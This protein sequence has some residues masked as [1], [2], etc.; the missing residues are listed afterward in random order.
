[1]QRQPPRPRVLFDDDNERIS[2]HD[3]IG[4]SKLKDKADRA[5]TELV[6]DPKTRRLLFNM[7]DQG[8]MSRM[9]GV[10]STGKEANVY[11]A[12]LD[13]EDGGPSVYKAVKVYK[14]SILV[15]KDR[16]RYVAGEHRFM[17]GLKKTSNKAMV[18]GWAE[19][20]YRNLRRLD[21]AKIPCPEPIKIKNNV[22]LM[23]FL[24]NEQGLAY[25]RLKDAPISQEEDA[26]EIW[27][28]LAIQALGLMRRL[29]RICSLVHAD[30][31]EYNI[32]YNDKT[33]Y[34]IDVSQSVEHH[35]P[36]AMEFLRMDVKNMSNFFRSKGVD[37]LR[38]STMIDFITDRKA[39]VSEPSMSTYIKNLYASRPEA[40]SEAE[41]AQAR[42]ADNDQ[43]RAMEFPAAISIAVP[44]E[45][46]ARDLDTML[47]RALDLDEDEDTTDEED[48]AEDATDDE[49]AEESQD[50]ERG[51]AAVKVPRGMRF[52]PKDEKKAHKLDVKEQ[53]REKRKTK[54][55]KNVKKRLVAESSRKKT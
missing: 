51:G 6:L 21:M 16:D 10:I 28:G 2:G 9:E 52:K 25:P 43:F 47:E 33:L 27:A 32:L 20:E 4:H 8:L 22:L 31:S 24:G 40:A 17:R 42:D 1:M 19:K 36:K 12:V 38:D 37:V 26:D 55:P 5:T 13:P 41:A 30:L 44:E 18:A 46:D 53:K 45:M 29:Y 35:H 34:I 50:E 15:F 23:S 49:D 7:I 48:E 3:G 14:T 39:P 11:G 54:M